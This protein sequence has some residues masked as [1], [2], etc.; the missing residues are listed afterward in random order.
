MY[1]NANRKL[2][3][4]EFINKKYLIYAHTKEGENE[5]L[6]D[7]TNLAVNYFLNI[8]NEKYLNEVFQKIEIEFLKDF[9]TQ[10]KELF[11][12]M[13][14]NAITLHDVGKVNPYFQKNRLKNDLKIKNCEK[15][16]NSHHSILSA[17]VYMDEYYERIK[18]FEEKEK[19]LLLD[20]MM[21]NAYIISRHHGNLNSWKDFK[22]KFSLG[23]EGEKL[24]E[25]QQLLFN[26]TLGKD[27][28]IKLKN[29]KKIFKDI[30]KHC[31]KEYSKNQVI[32]RYVYERLMLS[33]LVACDFYSTSE[34]M[35]NVE[36]SD[37]GVI[38]DVDEF[39]DVYKEG[40]IY[41]LI[42]GYEKKEYGKRSDFTE[43]KDINILRNELFLDTE[44]ALENNID[45][46]IFYLEAPTG[47]GKSNVAT[48]LS[49]KLLKEDKSKN[50]IFY[51]YPFNTLVEQNINTLKET[52]EKEKEIFNK[53]AVIN[54]IEPIKMDKEATKE[55]DTNLEYYK[56]ALLN[57]QF[58]N[59]PMILT[60][61][62]T[63]FKYLFGISKEDIFP[64][65]QLANSVIVLDEIQSYKNL[66]WGEIITFLSVYAKVLNIK[67]IIMSATLPNLDKLSLAKANTVRLI[68]NRE[69]YFENPIFKNR[70]QV[71][72][73]LLESEN[74]IDD[75]YE[76]VKEQSYKDKRILIEFI[77]KR[78]AYSFYNRLKEDE[79]IICDVELMS[80][81]DSIGE[82]DRIISKVKSIDSLLLVATQVVEAGVDIDMDIGYKNKSMLDSEEQFLGRINRSCKKENCIVYFFEIDD[83][84]KIYKEDIRRHSDITLE[85]ETIR[86]VLKGKDFD[87]FYNLVIERLKE[88]TNGYN[89][90]NI[91]KFFSEDV[92]SLEFGNVEERMRLIRQDQDK[93]SVYLSSDLLVNDEPFDGIEIWNEYKEL[94][95]NQD[96]DYS[97][98]RVELSR[99]RSK[100]NNFIYEIKWSNN[101]TYNDRIGDLYFIEDGD[102]YFKEG[103]LDKEK[104]INGIGDFI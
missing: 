5:K 60:T 66:I 56:K 3:I 20:F 25:D 37:I 69:K 52:F 91:E 14:L 10:G 63:I 92:R 7:H 80:G 44:K 70:V 76:D 95:N 32:Y 83:A 82:R 101:F 97:K 77:S 100:M 28:K 54:S 21:M 39:Y 81:D 59:Y 104:F 13:I 74:I 30:E 34:F 89:D 72:Y 26:E 102:S 12:E 41:N 85:N 47:S 15:F 48:N 24:L 19:Y 93:I 42:R 27:I 6:E 84:K 65:H 58:L 4:K 46:N 33:L 64:L 49:F 16:K 73:H 17:I 43:I 8:V 87:K 71:D 99:I 11:K 67:I 55:E 79:E 86:E 57:R 50:K 96:M 53:I 78:S 29:I 61:H 62:V 103:K 40:E 75:L 51:V 18:K 38:N 36:I 90:M 22:K 9:S 88:L 35:E 31:H 94:L 2:N 23:G 45:S 98:K 1:F 68:Q